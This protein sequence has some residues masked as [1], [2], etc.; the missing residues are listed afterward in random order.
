MEDGLKP[1]FSRHKDSRLKVDH[2]SFSTSGGAGK[3]A[4]LLV[5]SQRKIG[6]DSNLLT[7]TQSNLRESP[8]EHFVLTSLAALDQHVVAATKS[9]FISLARA[10][11]PGAKR[12]GLNI[13]AP[14]V[15]LHWLPGVF[16]H[17]FGNFGMSSEQRF[18]WTLHDF[19]P[20]TG[21]CHFPGVCGKFAD[22]CRGC[23]QVRQ[24]FHK[25]VEVSLESSASRYSE[26]RGVFVSP[27][28]GLQVAARQSKA[29]RAWSV[30]YIP[31][32]TTF[33][34]VTRTRDIVSPHRLRFLFVAANVNDKRKGLATVLSWWK[35]NASSFGEMRIVGAN[36]EAY[37]SKGERI[38]GLGSMGRFELLEEYS[39][40]DVL[41][42]AS[43]GD[44][45]PGVVADA[46]SLDV[47]ILYLGGDR[48]REWL[49]LDET[50]FVDARTFTN[51]RALQGY[52]EEIYPDK[53]TNFLDR[54]DPV[55]VAKSYSRIYSQLMNW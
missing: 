31:N 49:E 5:E 10:S 55:K 13:D 54:R 8:F 48:M 46:V 37:S 3:I 52:F 44:N 42:F 28:R 2:V 34:R 41:V 53:R 7:L 39:L 20:L 11:Y 12:D 6:L 27:S 16:D 35:E 33:T 30:H 29:G 1:I 19:R 14:L 24:I 25:Q 21:A 18:I 22:N 4:S 47:P 45:A 51:P 36:S 15:H 38:T 9:D 23:P 26:M 32:P 50:P 43:D 17:R 40:A